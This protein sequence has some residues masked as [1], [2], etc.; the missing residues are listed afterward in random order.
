MDSADCGLDRVLGAG[1]APAPSQ[2]G[3]MLR[4]AIN[5]DPAPARWNG[6]D[7]SERPDAAEAGRARV[8]GG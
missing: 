5:G 1:V 6:D 7:T 2:L 3:R 8:L 4:S